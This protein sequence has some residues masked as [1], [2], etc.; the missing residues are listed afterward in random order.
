MAVVYVTLKIMPT[1]PEV[2]LD[3][4]FDE[5]CIQIRNFVD[6]NHKESEIRKEVEEIGFGLKAV[7]ATFSMDES[8]GTT[9]PLEEEIGKLENVESVEAVDVRRA[10]G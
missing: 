5:A 3:A 7:K 4:L 2:D 1:A 8:L 10:F 9:D 6:D